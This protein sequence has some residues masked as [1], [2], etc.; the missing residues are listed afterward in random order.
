M[1]EKGRPTIMTPEIISKLEDVFA[2]GG[3]DEEACFYAGIGKS[4]LYNYQEKSPDFVE[5][6]EALKLKP[7]LKARQ[8]MIKDLDNVDS[9]KWYLE[10]KEPT[11]KNRID[12]TG[13]Q[14]VNLTGKIAN[15]NIKNATEEEIDNFLLGEL[16]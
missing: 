13:K 11:F 3:T 1:A 16:N 4:T 10:K 6:K 14:E 8:T 7:V 2:L 5:R 12:V 15:L 9:A